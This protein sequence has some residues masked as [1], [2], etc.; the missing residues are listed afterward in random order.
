MKHNRVM[1]RH[2]LEPLSALER[3]MKKA[4]SPWMVIGGVAASLL[5]KPRFTADVDVVVLIDDKDISDLLKSAEKFGVRS[6]I[7]NPIEFAKKNRVLLLHHIKSAINIDISLALLPF[8]KNALKNRI[9]HK[10]GNLTFYLP[11]PED[12]IIFKAVS[13]RPQDMVDIQEIVR[14]NARLDVRYIRRMVDEFAD[15]LEM[16]E[17]RDDIKVIIA[18]RFRRRH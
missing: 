4:S 15:A 6:R 1:P 5:G 3:L 12:L 16:P 17:I 8:E 11:I 14:N 13:H 7:A 9:R 2:L 18:A 10:V